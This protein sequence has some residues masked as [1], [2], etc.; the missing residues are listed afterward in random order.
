MKRYLLWLCVLILGLCSLLGAQEAFIKHSLVINIEVPV[1]VFQA[2]LFVNNLTIDDFEV[3][4]NDVPQKIEAVYLVNKRSIERSQEKTRFSP[5]TA[6]YF[7]LF[8]EIADY[9]PRIDEALDNFVNNIYLPGDNL[10]ITTPVSTYKLRAKSLE[11]KSRAVIAEELKGI[12]RKDT[13]S[14]NAD[15]RSTIRE[16]EKAAQ[17]LAA[18][19]SENTE[20]VPYAVPAQN[21]AV[22]PD[23]LDP[24]VL[25]NHHLIEYS[26]LLSKL[27]TM[28]Q[29]N[30][31]KM[32]DFARYLRSQEGQKYVFVFYQ[33]EFIP[34]VD[35]RILS[36][37]QTAN[38]QSMGIQLTL[39]N[40]MEFNKRNISVDV[41]KIKQAYADASTA[42]HFLFISKPAEV[43]YGVSME[44]HS[45]DIFAAFHEMSQAT[46]GLMISSANPAFAFQ[47]AL[48]A[49]E[50]YYLVYYVPKDYAGDGEFKTIKVKVKGKDY[51]VTHRKGYFA[52]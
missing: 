6:R 33:R 31:L 4:E 34:E 11:L 35:K 13:V 2:G 14:G 37:Y 17:A 29:V 1:R 32:M 12:L 40:L 21:A 20:S 3:W 38:Q 7:F 45:E 28:R 44:E 43:T 25:I 10:V 24:E 16:L 49:A 46:G 36:Q 47:Q 18:L 15:Y 19:F 9:M 52:Y 48:A 39:Q 41:D 23:A 22:D 51:N 50:N 8:F 42:I 26:Q 5:E 27:E 30:Q